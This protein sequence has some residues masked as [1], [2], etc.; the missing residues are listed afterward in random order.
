MIRENWNDLISNLPEATFLQTNEW[1]EI[2]RPNGWNSVK[3][4]WKEENGT[5]FAAAN[6]LFRQFSKFPLHIAYVPRGPLLDWADQERNRMVLSDLISLASKKNAIYIKIDPD[7]VIGRGLPGSEK[8]I[9][10][11]KGLSIQELLSKTGWHF[12]QDQIQFRNTV[13]ID[14]SDSEEKILARM[15]QKTRYNIRL[16]ERKGIVVSMA[17][18][19]EWDAIYRL[20]AE[21][22]DRDGFIIRPWEYYQRV[23]RILST[24]NMASCLKAEFNGKLIAAIWVV[25]F[26][27]KSHY[28]Y[29]MSHSQFREMMPNHLLQWRG[30]QLA[31][32]QGRIIY[33]MW[34]APNN[35]T[36]SDSLAGVFRFKQGF[37]GEIV[38]T[39]GAWDFPINKNLYNMYTQILPHILGIMRQDSRKNTSR[40]LDS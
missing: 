22:A 6:I 17:S 25:G 15:N 28:L 9:P 39:L 10:D 11:D 23:W 3:K 33:D 2:K 34:G 5:V 21:T 19:S 13:E 18:P 7:L 12:S 14:L 38:R 20:Y 16:A 32:S 26:G 31:K 29:G 8:D 37:G 24:A 4:V 27:T 30:M 40:F 36:K 35:F 1:S